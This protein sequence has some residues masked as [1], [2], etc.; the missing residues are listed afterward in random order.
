[1]YIKPLSYLPFLLMVLFLSA[2]T[3]DI[4]AAVN[5]YDG[6]RAKAGS[7]FLTYTSVYAADKITDKA[8]NTGTTP[9][10]GGRECK[11]Y[12]NMVRI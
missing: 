9:G 4:A 10:H 12:E 8:G 11:L 6:S 1:M 2:V 3:P 5:F 7:Y